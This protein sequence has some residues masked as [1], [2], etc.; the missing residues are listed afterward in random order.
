[1]SILVQPN[2]FI[3]YWRIFKFSCITA[4]SGQFFACVLII[5]I[6][7]RI[8]IGTRTMMTTTSTGSVERLATAFSKNFLSVRLRLRL[9][10]YL[11][12]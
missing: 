1:M 8:V 11:L 12:L 10:N 2:D 6:K 3:C 7:I 9:V 5:K 4:G